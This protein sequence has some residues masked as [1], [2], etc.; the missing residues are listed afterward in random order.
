M[1]IKTKM[2]FTYCDNK[3][4]QIAYN[5]LYPDNEGFIESEVIDNKLICYIE[6]EKIGT[7]LNT[8]EDL[9]Q[10]EKIIE[11]TSKIV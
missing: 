1:K 7:V 8:V 11:V 5:S 4:A 2:T 6:D 9:I 3:N 10:C